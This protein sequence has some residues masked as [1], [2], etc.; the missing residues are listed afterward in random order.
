MKKSLLLIVFLLFFIGCSKEDIVEQDVDYHGMESGKTITIYP[1]DKVIPRGNEAVI[2]VVHNSETNTKTVTLV[3]GSADL[4][5]D[6]KQF[7]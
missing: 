7:D 5:R 6:S 1:G 3:S 2:D 4:F